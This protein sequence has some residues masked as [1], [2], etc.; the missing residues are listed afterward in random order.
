MTWKLNRP[1]FESLLCAL[2]ALLL[3]AHGG[4][5]VAQ[6]AG[7]TGPALSTARPDPVQSP[8]GSPTPRAAE[9]ETPPGAIPQEAAGS[10]AP[11]GPV[12][13]ISPPPGAGQ[14]P[15][16]ASVGLASTDSPEGY[17]VGPGDVLQ[18]TVW[19]EPDVSGEFKVGPDGTV[20]HYLVG[21]VGVAGHSTKQIADVLR[22]A[23]AQ[24]YLRDPRVTVEVVDYQSQKVSVHGSI[25]RPGVYALRGPTDLLKLLL[26]AGGLTR[27]AGSECTLLQTG[28]SGGERVQG[29]TVRLDDLLVKG[30]VS[31]NRQVENGDVIYVHPKDETERGALGSEDRSYFVL[32]EV[33]NPG[34]YK[35]KEGISAMTAILD[36]GGFSE[37]ARS[38]KTKLV[39]D[40][41]GQKEE[42]TV[43]MGDVM[44]KGD[45]SLDVDLLPG[46]VI[47]VPKSFF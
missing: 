5:A 20:H 21:E 9:A 8:F 10:A 14:A 11:G 31:Q 27:D 23:L 3:V 36:A 2:T 18:I 22:D 46:D 33:K 16:R 42:K 15:A 43:K 38:N 41:D 34:A 4:T 7:A 39:R 35:Y 24:G 29:V 26:D 32:G 1:E 13:E 45:R 30:D 28:A 44:E 6:Q 12:T 17:T 47:V 37:Y 25:M 19:Q 40:K